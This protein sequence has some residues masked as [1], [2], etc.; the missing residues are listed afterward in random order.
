MQNVTDVDDPLLERAEQ[1]GQTWEELAEQQTELLPDDM[2]ALRVL[3]PDDYVG[4]V[5][6]VGCVSALLGEMFDSGFLYQVDDAEHRCAV[7]V[8]ATLGSGPLGES[9][10]NPE[11]TRSREGMQIPSRNARLALTEKHSSR[12]TSGQRLAPG[13]MERTGKCPF[14]NH[15]PR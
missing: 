3:P 14:A 4:A 12:S 11:L 6:C 8:S 13:L 2:A 1:T 5:E 7:V 15:W 10:V 9:G